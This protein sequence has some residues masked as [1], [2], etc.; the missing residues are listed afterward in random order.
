MHKVSKN[1]KIDAGKFLTS[2]FIV[3][4]FFAAFSCS[5][6]LV[7]RASL[8]KSDFTLNFLISSTAKDAVSKSLTEKAVDNSGKGE[9]SASRLLLSTA[10]TLVVTLTPIDSSVKTPLPKIIAL[11]SAQ[12]IP[13]NFEDIPYGSYTVLA[14][15]LA[16]DANTVLFSQTSTLVVKAATMSLTLNLVP[17]NFENIPVLTDHAINM[18]TILTDDAKTWLIPAGSALLISSHILLSMQEPNLSIYI[19]SKDGVLLAQASNTKFIATDIIPPNTDIYLT[20]YNTYVEN[21]SLNFCASPILV[22]V[23]EGN[24]QRDATAGNNS[25]VSA[26]SIGKYEVTR[27]QFNAIMGD[28]PVTTN[29]SGINDPVQNVNY[30]QAIA[31]CNKL[32]IAEGLSPV[33]VVSGFANFAAWSNLEYLSIP[34]ITNSTWNVVSIDFLANGYRLPT[35]MEWMWAS[36]GGPLDGQN[37]GTNTI[38]YNKGYAGSTEGASQVN[39][40]DYAWYTENSGLNG[41]NIFPQ[42]TH[43]VGTKLPNEL[44]LY[45][46]S[47]NVNEWTSDWNASY[48]IGVLRN[49]TGSISGLNRQMR[50]GSYLSSASNSKVATHSYSNP[51]EFLDS[52]CGFRLV[53]CSIPEKVFVYVSN[54]NTDS[55]NVFQLNQFT[56]ALGPQLSGSQSPATTSRM[57]IEPNKNFLFAATGAGNSIVSLKINKTSGLLSNVDSKPA[58]T[59]PS[60]IVIDESGRFVYVSNSNSA[61]ISAYSFNELTGVLTL[62]GTFPTASGG[63]PLSIAIKGSYLY[64]VSYLGDL[65]YSALQSF[66]INASTGTLGSGKNSNILIPSNQNGLAILGNFLY[67]GEGNSAGATS[68][69]FIPET[70]E[71]LSACS[72][73]PYIGW[74]IPDTVCMDPLGEYFFLPIGTN[75]LY[76]IPITQATG[77]FGTAVS[78]GLSAKYAAFDPTAKYLLTVDATSLSSHVLNRSTG[79][80]SSTGFSTTTNPGPSSILSVVLP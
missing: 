76:T 37:G 30:Y 24:F 14:E 65:N 68:Y 16:P 39:I 60:D 12:L 58:G 74:P 66:L 63:S 2:L 4:A 50:G 13:V 15:A 3:M 34:I 25:Y 40:G 9:S 19:Q 52:N 75:S 31:F 53:R 26:F 7:G 11:G 32:S 77:L 73:T 27:A 61:S 72:S 5:S 69:S 6:P 42:K 67:V 56:G 55:I 59:N 38:A 64:C 41:T 36:M 47:G 78:S 44:G 43:P 28:D 79:L 46:M 57:V 35:E 80:F 23:P 18:T 1:F 45:D 29:S 33:Y 22:P 54:S 62:I 21:I 51:P 8:P 70:G 20:L 10:K 17:K 71:I 48:P 49:Y